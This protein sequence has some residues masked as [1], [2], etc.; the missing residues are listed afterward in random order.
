M[1]LA[2]ICHPLVRSQMT[3]WLYGPWC[4]I[5][6]V[7][8]SFCWWLAGGG[9][10]GLDEFDCNEVR[11]WFCASC[12]LKCWNALSLSG[13]DGP[14]CFNKWGG[15]GLRGY[16]G[17][18][19]ISFQHTVTEQMQTDKGKSP[20]P[21]HPTCHKVW[22]N[23]DPDCADTTRTGAWVSLPALICAWCWVSVWWF[24]CLNV[25][26]LEQPLCYPASNS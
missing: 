25:P 26:G 21:P 4:F 6:S 1:C 13:L 17:D 24:V 9:G 19:V 12:L 7:W 14:R 11:L 8:G 20:P 18:D 22:A 10:G 3:W 5:F 16:N 15:R 23:F 2:R